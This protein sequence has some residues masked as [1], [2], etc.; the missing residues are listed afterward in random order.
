MHFFEM[1]NIEDSTVL[2]I[3]CPVLSDFDKKNS[4]LILETLSFP[5]LFSRRKRKPTMRFQ[6]N[7]IVCFNEF[8]VSDGN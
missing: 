1:F 2:Q 8:I 7:F 6:Y 5:M 4:N 3:F